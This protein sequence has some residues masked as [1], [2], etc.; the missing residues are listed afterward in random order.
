[1]QHECFACKQRFN[2]RFDFFASL[3][4]ETI[5]MAGS[6]GNA[7]FDDR[8]A[9]RQ[10]IKVPCEIAHCTR[11]QVLRWNDG[12]SL[13]RQRMQIVF[14]DVPLNHLKWIAKRCLRIHEMEPLGKLFDAIVVVP[15]RSQDGA[16]KVIPSNRAIG[17]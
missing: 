1:M 13:F 16:P 7:W 2:N 15:S 11:L 14:V 17:P 9:H 8:F 6:C 12:R 3:A 10:F 5:C 4:G